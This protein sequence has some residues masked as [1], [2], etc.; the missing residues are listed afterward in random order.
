MAES[1]SKFE[2]LSRKEAKERGLTRYF[3][4]CCCPRQHISERFVKSAGCVKCTLEKT[5]ERR[6]ADPEHTREL[7]RK[8]R[9]ENRDRLNDLDRKRYWNNPEKFRAKGKRGYWK[10]PERAKSRWATYFR[11]RYLEEEYRK[12]AQHR[13]RK[14]TEDNPEQ[15][16]RNRRVGASRRRTRELNAVG[17]FT[18]Q[19]IAELYAAQNGR[20]IYCNK[21]FQQKYHVDHIQPISRGGTNNRSN[22]QLLCKPCNL[23]KHCRDPF[24]HAQSIGLLL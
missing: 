15:A 13:T 22:L 16:A 2:L 24:V 20:C 8:H 4:G 5:K 6:V 21:Q 7:N 3:T 19:D 9:N 18:S 12:A 23:A 1:D 10:D 11:K 14:W 17:S